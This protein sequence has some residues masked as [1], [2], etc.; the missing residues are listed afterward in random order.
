MT[1]G[2]WILEL[3]IVFSGIIWEGYA[4]WILYFDRVKENNCGLVVEGLLV[5]LLSWFILPSGLK[6]GLKNFIFPL[7]FLLGKARSLP[8]APRYFSLLYDCLDECVDNIVRSVGRH[9]VHAYTSFFG[10]FFFFWGK[11][12]N[13]YAEIM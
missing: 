3:G 9:D 6:D 1:I 11:L 12:W 2:N 4:S 13:H 8:L 7:Q 5:Y 10:F